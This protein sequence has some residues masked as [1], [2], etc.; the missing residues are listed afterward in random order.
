M[1]VNFISLYDKKPVELWGADWQ[2]VGFS[3]PLRQ[4]Q[5]EEKSEAFSGL[6]GLLD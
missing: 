3:H 2:Y 4:K 5:E 1:A 6:H